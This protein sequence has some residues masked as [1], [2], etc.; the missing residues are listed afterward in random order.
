[1]LKFL[2]NHAQISTKHWQKEFYCWCYSKAIQQYCKIIWSD[3]YF[4]PELLDAWKNTQL[5]LNFTLIA[6]VGSFHVN[7]LREKRH[8]NKKDISGTGTRTL[9]SCVK[10]KYVNHLH[11]A[12]ILNIFWLSEKQIYSLLNMFQHVSIC[13]YDSF[14]FYLSAGVRCT[15]W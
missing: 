11:H 15:F 3:S 4:R 10:G 13:F 14:F 9:G 12:G 2:P 1:M 6:D 5:S 8:Q 7:V